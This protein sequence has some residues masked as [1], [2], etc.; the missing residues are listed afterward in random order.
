MSSEPRATVTQRIQQGI[1]AWDR[2][3]YE[4]ALSIFTDVLREHPQ[5]PDLHHRAGLCRAMLSDLEG[6]IEAF[7]R[8]LELAPT[9]AEAHF[10]RGIVLNDLGRHDEAE[11]SFRRAQEL[12]TR[13]GTRFPSQVGN[14]IANAHAQLGDLYMI[15]E[16]PAEASEQYRL[17]LKVRPRFLD[18]REKLA[19]ALLA[20]DDAEGAKDE[21]ER[22]LKD[23]PG[24]AEAR[25]RLGIAL[26]RLGDREGAV[27]EWTRVYS[28]RPDDRRVLAYLASAGIDPDD[29]QR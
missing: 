16:S 12:D 29:L 6:A 20:S 22:V 7:D 26:Q 5:Y 23:R 2:N 1:A 24:F 18:I 15:A 10:N 3:A 4:E 9:Y 17:A 27:R 14:Q 19:E 21:L 25:L 13:D 11:A 28:E 8:A